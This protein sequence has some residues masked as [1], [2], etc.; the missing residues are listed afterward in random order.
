[1][2]QILVN[3]SQYAALHRLSTPELESHLKKMKHPQVVSICLDMASQLRSLEKLLC[4]QQQHS[5]RISLGKIQIFFHAKLFA[6]KIDWYLIVADTL[7]EKLTAKILV[8]IRIKTIKAMNLK[9]SLEWVDSEVYFYPQY[10]FS[11]M[12]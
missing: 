10:S 7:L 6:Q 2:R 12:F 8:K 9:I 1:M 5:V 3:V 4:V 11:N